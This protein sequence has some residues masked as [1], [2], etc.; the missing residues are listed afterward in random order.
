MARATSSIAASGSACWQS[1]ALGPLS[2]RVGWPRP[3]SARPQELPPAVSPVRSL[4]LALGR[5]R[6][7]L[8]RGC[9]SWRHAGVCTSGRRGSVPPRSNIERVGHQHARP[10]CCVAKG[11]VEIVRSGQRALWRGGGSQGAAAIL[12]D[13]S[14]REY[15]NGPLRRAVMRLPP[16][17]GG[18]SGEVACWHLT[19]MPIGR[20]SA[21]RQER[22]IKNLI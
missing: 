6:S 14:L 4:R 20:T 18:R 17:A 11:R 8:R 12:R 5:G 21:L 2:P 22:S 19:D 15:G 16:Q 9:P 13:A 3:R 1:R 10:E 7:L